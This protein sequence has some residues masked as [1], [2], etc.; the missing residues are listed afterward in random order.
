MTKKNSELK[1]IRWIAR[2]TGT[3]LSVSILIFGAFSLTGEIKDRGLSY[4][5]AQILVFLFW[6]IA[7]LA[8][9]LAIWREGLGGIIAISGLILMFISGLF[10]PEANKIGMLWVVL[11]LAVPSILYIYYWRENRKNPVQKNKH[12]H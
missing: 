6:G 8:L 12:I 3:L 5:P 11:I 10:I 9:L 7:L 1:V 4:S 2:I